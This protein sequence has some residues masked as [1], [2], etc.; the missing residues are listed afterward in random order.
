MSIFVEVQSVAPKS[1]KL[2]VNLDD[3]IEIAP[4]V[5][6]GCVLYFSTQ[7]SGTPRTMTVSDEYVAFK[8]FVMQP[9]TVDSI[10]KRFPSKSKSVA[11][12]S[13]KDQGTSGVE[14]NIPSF[15]ALGAGA[16]G[17]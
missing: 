14:L 4:L 1:C 15:G 17:A 7:E 10:E 3:I 16:V 8:Q 9:V 5:S 11:T 6:G 12:P 2:I 13:I